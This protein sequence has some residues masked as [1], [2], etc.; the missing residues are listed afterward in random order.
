MPKNKFTKINNICKRINFFL[1]ISL[2]AK[3][4]LIPVTFLKDIL[5][6]KSKF[7]SCTAYLKTINYVTL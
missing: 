2:K 3:T 7:L 6:T 4:I 1:L 5:T